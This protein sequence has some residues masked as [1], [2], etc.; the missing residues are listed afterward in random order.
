MVADGGVMT[1]AVYPRLGVL[2]DER[3]LTVAELARRLRERFGLEVN[4]KTLYRLAQDAPVQRADLEIAGAAA[5]LLGVGLDDLFAV[6]AVPVGGDSL[7]EALSSEQSRRLAALFALRAERALSGEEQAELDALVTAY[8]HDQ[9]ERTL[10]DYAERQHLGLAEAR[11]AVGADYVRALD[12]WRT[13]EADP[14]RRRA[15]V[16]RAAAR[17]AARGG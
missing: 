2:L 14:Q 8:G 11:E 3:N 13:F 15:A 10:H 17:R 5:A 1:V 9:Y 6:E 16:A 7:P 12:W 4:L